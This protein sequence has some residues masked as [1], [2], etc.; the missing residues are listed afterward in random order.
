MQRNTETFIMYL[1]G[2][3]FVSIVRAG[4]PSVSSKG[5]VE[6]SACRTQVTCEPATKD[7][8]SA[9]RHHSHTAVYMPTC[10]RPVES[11]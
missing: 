6:M 3:N 2:I 8:K 9:Y 11:E 1:P 4:I 10:K 7:S 5:H